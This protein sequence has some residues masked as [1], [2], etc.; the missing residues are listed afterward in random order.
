VLSTVGAALLA[1]R[2]GPR[3]IGAWAASILIDV[4]HYAWFCLSHRRLN[5]LQAVRFFNEAQPPQHR[6][7][8]LLHDPRSLAAALLVGRRR[9]WAL[10][11]AV[12]MSLHVALDAW[13][14]LR[15]NEARVA[16]LHR[17]DFT[18]QRCGLRG[19]DVGTH[20]WRQPLLLPRFAKENVVSLCCD[21]HEA[22]HVSG[23]RLVREPALRVGL[24]GRAVRPEHAERT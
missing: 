1:R 23:T 14:E 2:F 19:P 13:Y 15:M 6:A 18:C 17:D 8:R 21:C 11:L 20:V 22:A 24:P 9:R 4:D 7:T 16:A 12:G 10:P 3:V 5:L